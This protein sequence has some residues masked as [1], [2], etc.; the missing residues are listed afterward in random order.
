MFTPETRESLDDILTEVRAKR[1][2]TEPLPINY[3]AVGYGAYEAWCAY[4]NKSGDS[5]LVSFVAGYNAALA[6][7][8]D[9]SP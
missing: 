4:K 9:G 2:P 3:R 7:R 5:N 6:A 8:K 1:F